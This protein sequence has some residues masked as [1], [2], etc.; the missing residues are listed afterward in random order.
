MLIVRASYLTVLKWHDFRAQFGLKFAV[1]ELIDV[2]IRLSQP[3]KG[4][5]LNLFLDD[6]EL[7]IG[8]PSL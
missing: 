7:R 5:N 4:P 2:L 8:P 3:L 6:S 1:L